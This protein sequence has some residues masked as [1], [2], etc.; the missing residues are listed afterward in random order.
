M[1]RTASWAAGS[2]AAPDPNPGADAAARAVNSSTAPSPSSG[3][4]AH[5]VSP[6]RASGS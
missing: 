4:T 2:S 1:A 3:S 6:A 5:S